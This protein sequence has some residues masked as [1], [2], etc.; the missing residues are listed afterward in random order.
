VK[1]SLLMTLMGAFGTPML[2]GGD[3][4][5][6]TQKGNNNAYCQDNEISWFDWKLLESDEGAKLARF[7]RR[8]VALRHAFLRPHD[9]LHGGEEIIPGVADIEWFDERGLRLSDE[10]W[11]NVEGRALILYVSRRAGEGCAVVTALAMNAS[12]E[13][14]DYHLLEAVRW[15]LLLDSAAPEMEASALNQP[16]HRIEPRAAALLEGTFEPLSRLELRCDA[17]MKL[18]GYSDEPTR[19]P[20]T[21]PMARASWAGQQIVT[22]G[23]PSRAPFARRPGQREP[24]SSHSSRDPHR[25][26]EV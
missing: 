15:R 24:Y 9:F 4:F 13:P 25:R 1:R 20:A 22:A 23:A 14:L 3:E 19:P 5:G 18:L 12:H 21:S 17:K 2:L 16:F 8:I 10:D 26:T 11:R 7:V 6:R